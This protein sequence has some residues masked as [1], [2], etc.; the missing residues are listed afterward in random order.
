VAWLVFTLVRGPLVGDY[1]PYPFLDVAQ[2]GHPTVLVNSAVVA[3]L[4]LGLAAGAHLLDRRL[5][6]RLATRLSR[7]F[8][9]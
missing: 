9:R 1:Y 3:V 6:D 4:F 5:D 7:A 2:H 8:G